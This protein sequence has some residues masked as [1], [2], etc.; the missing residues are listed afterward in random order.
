MHV[1]LFSERYVLV[2]LE[3]HDVEPFSSVS[4]LCRRLSLIRYSSHASIGEDI[5]RFLECY[6]ELER[7][8]GVET[9]NKA[10]E[11][12]DA[13]LAP[14]GKVA[15]DAEQRDEPGTAARKKRR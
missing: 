6:G 2:V 3:N 15:G 12:L 10:Y 9:L 7:Q 14:L 13:L 11:V 1:P 5:D 8:A 4:N